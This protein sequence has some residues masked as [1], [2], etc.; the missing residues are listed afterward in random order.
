MIS[1]MKNCLH[2]WIDVKEEDVRR[3]S[4]MMIRKDLSFGR[5]HIDE[6]NKGLSANPDAKLAIINTLLRKSSTR[7]NYSLNNYV[8]DAE[9]EEKED[10]SLELKSRNNDIPRIQTYQDTIPIDFRIRKTTTNMEINGLRH[11]TR[12][13]RRCDIYNKSTS[14]LLR[15]HVQLQKST[16]TSATTH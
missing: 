2:I 12:T 14:R 13:L 11:N 8:C 9:I 4:T 16:N 10:K 7:K 1:I 3:Y 15:T 6:L 5:L